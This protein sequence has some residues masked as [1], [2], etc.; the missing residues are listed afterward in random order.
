VAAIAGPRPPGSQFRS[1]A[2]FE[3]ADFVS[4]HPNQKKKK[5][6]KVKTNVKADPIEMQ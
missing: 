6:M 2:W 1:A 5:A 3:E 4:E